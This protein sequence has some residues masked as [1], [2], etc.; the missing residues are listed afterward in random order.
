MV[1]T[2]SAQSMHRR[3]AIGAG[4]RFRP[5]AHTRSRLN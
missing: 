3:I 4:I 2:G 5:A 1:S